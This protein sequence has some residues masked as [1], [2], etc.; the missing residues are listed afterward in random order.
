MTGSACGAVGWGAGGALDQHVD[1]AGV[2]GDVLADVEPE[3][4]VVD[5]A[6]AP[7][8]L[9]EGGE[10]PGVVTLGELGEGFL[11]SFEEGVLVEGDVVAFDGGA[12]GVAEVHGGSPL[13]RVV[14]WE[15]VEVLVV[16]GYALVE[17]LGGG[18]VEHERADG[19]GVFVEQEVELRLRER[20]GGAEDSELH[21][22]EHG[23]KCAD[24][25]RVAVDGLAD[26]INCGLVVGW[27][28]ARHGG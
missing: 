17:D 18:E 22:R 15:L 12:A 28:G 5:G 24:L 2:V 25:R 23:D 4:V 3:A 14:G 13:G 19:V 21:P 7:A 20:E 1:L 16:E 8:G 9:L 10:E 27:G 6:T 11:A 26:E